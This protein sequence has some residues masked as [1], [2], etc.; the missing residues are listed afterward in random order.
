M[1]ESY[2]RAERPQRKRDRAAAQNNF[3]GIFASFSAQPHSFTAGVQNCD[4]ALHCALYP[5]FPYTR[6]ERHETRLLG[7]VGA[8][9]FEVFG[10]EARASHR[11]RSSPRDA[12]E[13]HRESIAIAHVG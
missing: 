2:I 3:M 8:L 1:C 6:A 9:L 11:D 7:L 13:R 12:F 5:T 10:L 4:N